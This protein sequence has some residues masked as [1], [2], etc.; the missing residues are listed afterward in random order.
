[1]WNEEEEESVI[2]GVAGFDAE[3]SSTDR[4]G[5][6]VEPPQFDVHSSGYGDV[7]EADPE[8]SKEEIG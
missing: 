8:K 5:C 6:N 7:A 3:F 4:E 1:V 2:Q